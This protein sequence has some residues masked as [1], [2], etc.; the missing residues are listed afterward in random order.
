MFYSI[1]TRTHLLYTTII[2]IIPQSSMNYYHWKEKKT[3]NLNI[4]VR[5]FKFTIFIK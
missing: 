3:K 1:S 5:S 2:I 4:Y